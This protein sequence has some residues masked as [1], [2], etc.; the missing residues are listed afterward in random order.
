MNLFK[1]VSSKNVDAKVVQK[2]QVVEI[3]PAVQNT[4][5]QELTRGQRLADKFAAQ[6]GSWGFLIGQSTVLAGW[7]GIN[8]MPGVPHWDESPFMM[9]NLVFSFASAYTAPIV[10]MSQNRQSDTDRKNSEI[11]HQ[12][13]LRAGQNIELLHEKLDDLHTQQLNELTQIVKEQQRVLHELKVSLVNESKEVKEIKEFKLSVLPG[14]Y[15]Q[16]GA[17]LPKQVIVN[18]A[19]NFDQPIGD[20]NKV[21]D[22]L[23]RR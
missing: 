20:N 19:F 1:K 11:D 8:L 15:V 12:V 21:I 10:L 22:K 2:P 16:N 9:L 14:I 5:T 18:K 13:N 17:Q 6:V 4:S 3:Q 23:I 7:V